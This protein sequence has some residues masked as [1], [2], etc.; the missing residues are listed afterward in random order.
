MIDDNFAAA[1]LN[2]IE[3]KFD[4]KLG[5]IHDSLKSMIA[6][7]DKLNNECDLD[8]EE[9]NTGLKDINE[10]LIR[11]DNNNAEICNICDRIIAIAQKMDESMDQSE[12]CNQDFWLESYIYYLN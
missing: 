12:N 1:I 9:I 6:E 5:P 2:V 4:E 3:M 7:M 8:A 11:I 10:T